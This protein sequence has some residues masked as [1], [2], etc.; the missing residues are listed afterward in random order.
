MKK[1]A[2]L[3]DTHMRLK[4]IHVCADSK[5][6]SKSLYGRDTQPEASDRNPNRTLECTP[7]RLSLNIRMI[8]M[9]LDFRQLT[10]VQMPMKSMI[11]LKKRLATIIPYGVFL[12]FC[13]AF[14]SFL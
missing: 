13:F 10:I 2:S 14:Y 6:E 3:E 1:V 8:G 5:S 7:K 11:D 12:V 9:L 4:E